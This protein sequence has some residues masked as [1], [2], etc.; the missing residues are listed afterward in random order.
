MHT[1]QLEIRRKKLQ[2]LLRLEDEQYK[3][4]YIDRQE[5][6]EDIRKRMAE[7]LDQLKSSR[8]F[9]RSQEVNAKY[10]QRWRESADELRNQEGKL[11]AIHCRLH[12]EKQM[13]EKE[14]QELMNKEEERIY[15]ELWL[16]DKQK[17][18]LQEL[19]RLKKKDELNQERLRY[20]DWQRNLR[21]NNRKALSEREQMEK[22]MLNEEWDKEKQREA[23]LKRER[24]RIL[25]DRN[26]EIIQHNDLTKQ[27]KQE[28]EQ[29]ERD[30]DRQLIS[31]II[32]RE[33][34]EEQEELENKIRRRLEAKDMIKHYNLRSKQEGD[35]ERMIEE[36]AK[37][38]NDEQW[39]RL[40]KKWDMEEKARIM[41]MTEVYESRARDISLKRQ[42][43]NEEREKERLEKERIAREV[44]QAEELERMRKTAARLNKVQN[45]DH[46][47]W[48][49]EEKERKKMMGYQ[50]EML[51]KRAAKLAEIQYQKKI[52]DEKKKGMELLDALRAKR[53]Y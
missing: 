51:E 21:E 28:E 14:Q 45:Q 12:Q 10:E 34:A 36:Y 30:L 29:R 25:R 46:L 24:D 15:N 7:R 38:E 5:T 2:D 42:R 4:E 37:A 22:Q 17:K 19:E 47:R 16:Q 50:E 13:W 3:K 49:I 41:L 9:E 40:D 35:L 39:R 52:E 32:K 23:A 31:E 6:P 26:L 44:A 48:Q 8:E 18:D 53:P 1:Q 33:E 43:E 20:L 27:L 11:S